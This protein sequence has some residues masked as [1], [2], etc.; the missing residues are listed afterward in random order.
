MY[1]GGSILAALILLRA[2]TNLEELFQFSLEIVEFD[3]SL[4]LTTLGL[5]VTRWFWFSTKTS[6]P[7]L[8]K[9]H[10]NL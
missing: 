3:I 4:D 1:L 6:F 5:T 2:G 7:S 9:K 8:K 10:L